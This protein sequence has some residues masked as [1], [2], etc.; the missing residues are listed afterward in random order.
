MANLNIWTNPT[1]NEKRV[2]IDVRYD[3]DAVR[4]GFGDAAGCFICADENGMAVVRHKKFFDGRYGEAAAVIAD[5]FAVTGA[6]FADLLVRVA[7]ARGPRGGKFSEKVYF[8]NLMKEA[9]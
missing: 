9:A 3:V 5:H 2:Y 6:T 4:L 7:N 8:N 1:T